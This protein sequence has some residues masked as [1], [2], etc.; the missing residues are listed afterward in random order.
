MSSRY[1]NDANEFLFNFFFNSREENFARQG[2]ARILSQ[3]P[4]V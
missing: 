3:M 2:L 4:K 1:A